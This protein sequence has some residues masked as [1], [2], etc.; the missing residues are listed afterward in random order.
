MIVLN[1]SHPLTANQ[2]AAI[3]TIKGYPI[4]QLID[5][6]CQFDN[7]AEFE[8]QIR[9]IIDAIDIDQWEGRRILIVPPGLAPAAAVLLAEFHGRLGHF[10]EIVRIRPNHNAPEPYEVAE[11]INL[12]QVREKARKTRNGVYNG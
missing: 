6:P 1:F 8:P 3:E 4:A 9:S 5:I 11:I 12:Q 10:P 7:A 2:R